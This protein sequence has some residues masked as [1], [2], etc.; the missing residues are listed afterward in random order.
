MLEIS[1]DK[2]TK[3]PTIADFNKMSWQQVNGSMPVLDIL[4]IDGEYATHEDMHENKTCNFYIS[5]QIPE[6]FDQAGYEKLIYKEVGHVIIIK[7]IGKI[8]KPKR[9][10]FGRVIYFK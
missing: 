5:D 8:N 1:N 3:K 7:P 4:I 2:I 6:T 10:R 9:S